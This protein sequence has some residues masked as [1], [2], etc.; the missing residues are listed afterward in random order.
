MEGGSFMKLVDL[1]LALAVVVAAPAL[2]AR[3][4]E[5]SGKEELRKSLKDFDEA[6][7]WVYDDLDAGFAAARKSAKPVLVVFR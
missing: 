2:S 4:E 7:S 6:A 1:T 3:A 5:A